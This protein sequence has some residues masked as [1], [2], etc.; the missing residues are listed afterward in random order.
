M[1]AWL[2]RAH[3]AQASETGLEP[4]SASFW[5]AR[6]SA[7]RKAQKTPDVSPMKDGQPSSSLGED[8]DLDCGDP[9]DDDDD[10][11]DE[12][13]D[14]R[15]AKMAGNQNASGSSAS[16]WAQRMDE[17]TL[18]AEIIA[19]CQKQCGCVHRFGLLSKAK[20]LATREKLAGM[21]APERRAWMRAYLDRLGARGVRARAALARR[22][23][24]R[25]PWHRQY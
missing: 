21:C 4:D 16:R 5:L 23:G 24:S 3:A 12:R 18:D 6:A 2:A 10:D 1:A 9:S 19:G 7:K 17:A 13:S 15:A 8:D 25:V 11:D 14:S 20:C 22:A